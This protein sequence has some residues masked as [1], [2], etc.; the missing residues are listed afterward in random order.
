VGAYRAGV[1]E[2]DIEAAVPLERIVDDLLHRFLVGGV[3]LACVDVDLGPRGVDLALVR[4]EVGVVIVTEVDGL[5]SVRCELMGG[6]PADDKD[7]VCPCS[8]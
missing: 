4:L 1:G 5:G 6:S 3:K 2:E 8:V 7:G